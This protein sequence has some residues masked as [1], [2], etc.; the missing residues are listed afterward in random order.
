[1][2]GLKTVDPDRNSK[3]MYPHRQARLLVRNSRIKG[4]TLL[5]TKIT[6]HILRDASMPP[7]GY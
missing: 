4:R 2:S 7:C 5:T 3:G 1:M 6:W